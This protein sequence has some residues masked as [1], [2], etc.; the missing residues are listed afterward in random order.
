M[1]LKADEGKEGRIRIG[2]YYNTLRG[3]RYENPHFFEEL[4]KRN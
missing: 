4:E 1:I 2:V 3:S